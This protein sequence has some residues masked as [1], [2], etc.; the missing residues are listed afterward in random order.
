[1]TK[2]VSFATNASRQAYQLSTDSRTHNLVLQDDTR[3]QVLSRKTTYI[4]EG[5]AKDVHKCS[6]EI[7]EIKKLKAKK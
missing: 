6:K 4:F 3:N 7:K 2:A 1:M 5:Q